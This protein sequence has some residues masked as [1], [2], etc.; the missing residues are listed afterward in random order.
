MVKL[1]DL[2]DWILDP[3]ISNDERFVDIA[4]HLKYPD[5]KQW[6]ALLPAR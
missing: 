1:N 5:L 2:K 3:Q 6:V 4:V